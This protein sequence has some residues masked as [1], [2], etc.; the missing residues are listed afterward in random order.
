MHPRTRAEASGYEFT[1]LHADV[2]AFLAALVARADPRLVVTSFG[3][4]PQ[5]RDLPLVVLSAHGIKTP[6][7]S[8]RL[9]LPVVLVMCGIHAGEVEGKEAGLMLTRDL[10]A[11]PESDLLAHL[12]LVLVPLFNYLLPELMQTAIL[13]FTLSWFILGILFFPF[14]WVISWTF[15]RR[16]MALEE[17]EAREVS[18]ASNGGKKRQT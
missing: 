9:G 2:M 15:I 17:A 6:A 11:G 5:G 16:S 10:L 4:S 14:V 1:S 18:E 7:A 3:A 12:T 8:R 13:G